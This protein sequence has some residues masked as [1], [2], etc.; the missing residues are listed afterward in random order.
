MVS[1]LKEIGVGAIDSSNADVQKIEEIDR[2]NFHS[3]WCDI[4]EER[5]ILWKVGYGDPLS[6]CLRK[7]DQK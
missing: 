1:L 7:L 5:G 4:T 6:K 2:R 3:C